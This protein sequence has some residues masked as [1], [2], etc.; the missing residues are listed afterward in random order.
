MLKQSLM[1]NKHAG[2]QQAAG[3]YTCRVNP[4]WLFHDLWDQANCQGGWQMQAKCFDD[5]DAHR[6]AQHC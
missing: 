3:E 4:R 1:Q 5:E 2:E 6:H